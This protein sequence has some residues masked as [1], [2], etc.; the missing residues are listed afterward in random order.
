M[1]REIINIEQVVDTTS[2]MPAKLE[3]KLKREYPGNPHAVY[4]TLNKI[5]AMYGNKETSKGKR[6]ERHM[7]KT[8]HKT[9]HT[10]ALHRIMKEESM[11][12]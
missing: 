4:G 1:K 2:N 11:S 5:G 10:K 7:L 8:S 3:A 12:K 6:I 9:P